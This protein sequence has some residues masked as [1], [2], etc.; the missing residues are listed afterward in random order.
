M[1]DEDQRRSHPEGSPAPFDAVLF[2]SYG[3][4]RAEARERSIEPLA[5]ALAKGLGCVRAPLGSAPFGSPEPSRQGMPR[6]VEAYT[7]AKARRVLA[8]RGVEVP[9]VSEALHALARSGARR[10]LVQPGHL[11][12]GVAFEQVIRA[13]ERC[14]FL[15]ARLE[16]GD[17][18]LTD[19]DDLAAVASALVS[20]YPRHDGE[21]LVFVAHGAEDGRV[22]AGSAYTSLQL[23]LR[24]LGRDDAFVGSMRA[25]PQLDDV[26]GLVAME[27]ERLGATR[28]R[29]V[30]LMLT[31]AAH[32]SLDIDGDRPGTWRRGFEA[33]G[34]QVSSALVGLGELGEVR[35]VYVR[36]ARRAWAERRERP[37]SSLEASGEPVESVDSVAPARHGRFPLFVDL[38]GEGCLV[39]G[40]GQVGLRRAR[41]LAAFGAKVVAVDPAP[42]P[43]DER[44]A[45]LIGIRLERRA[46]V[47]ADVEDRRLVVAATDSRATNAE[48]ARACAAARV[49]V[50]VADSAELSTC[51]FP[52]VCT[53]EHLVAG[54]VSD[55]SHHELVSRAAEL[56]RM[57][58]GE[59]D[60]D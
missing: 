41:M 23:R 30:P 44:E 18:L 38:S 57:A 54:V 24:L 4:S 33:D 27:R 40:L 31:A 50:S 15:F 36:H 20:R 48:V 35:D 51:F 58:L 52:A 49:P 26:R 17:P 32:A 55:G 3:T 37:E 46:W 10:V 16:L 28:V 25:F 12:H 19:E 13:V 47:P 2:A 60:G 9:D 42:R 14:R 21:A 53:S 34:F 5:E 22:G 6:L 11:V 56:V 59:V 8:R 1:A 7:S 39:V 29:L 45:G 43:E